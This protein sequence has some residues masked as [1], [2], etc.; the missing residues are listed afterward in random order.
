MFLHGSVW[1][2]FFN[3]LILFFF[4]T[5][6]EMVWGQK[7]FLQYYLAC[8]VGAGLLHM[9]ISYNATV[10]GAS[11]GVYAVL[12]AYAILYPNQYVLL[13][14]VLPVRV[15]YLVIGLAAFDLLMGIRG[16]DGIAHFAHIGGAITGLF[17]FRGEIRRKL[18]I[19]MGAKKKW[20]GYVHERRER[21]TDVDSANIDSILDKISEK[22]LENL[23]T[24]EKRILENYSRKQKEQSDQD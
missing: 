24:T 13:M 4:G 10:I 11:G 3:M 22:G 15:K 8:G 2:L 7:R 6:L 21:R 5:T 23:T 19:S 16:G 1:H 20:Q 14:F 17:F 18:G 12:M 9:A